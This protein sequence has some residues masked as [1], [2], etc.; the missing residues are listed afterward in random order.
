MVT[1]CTLLWTRDNTLGLIYPTTISD[2]VLICSNICH[3]GNVI[4]LGATSNLGGPYN[5]Y[6]NVYV[7]GSI[8]YCNNLNFVSGS[9]VV[10]TLSSNGQL[11]LNKS[12]T[13]TLD[14]GGNANIDNNLY[15]GGSLTVTGIITAPF[16]SILRGTTAQRDAYFVTLAGGE[17][18][19]NTSTS[20]F[21]IYKIGVGW[22]ILG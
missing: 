20:E 13:Q 4:P 18:W 11:G 12:P 19:Y 7:N 6:G 10:A 8:N 14:V 21:E 15:V 1:E 16:V 17:V 22:V 5:R 3:C 9:T 2:N